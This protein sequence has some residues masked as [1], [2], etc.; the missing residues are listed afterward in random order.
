MGASCEA[1]VET[2]RE[3]RGKKKELKLITALR[4]A[5]VSSISM[6]THLELRSA[7]LMQGLFL[8]FNFLSVL[9]G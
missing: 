4:I 1:A 9:T 6:A 2:K 7:A 5:L 3:E 8:F